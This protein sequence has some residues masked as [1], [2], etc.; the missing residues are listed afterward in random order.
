MVVDVQPSDFGQE[1]LIL[2]LLYGCL[3]HAPVIYGPDDLER[4]VASDY[5][6]WL[7]GIRDA[8]S[9]LPDGSEMPTPG[10]L[11]RYRERLERTRDAIREMRA[12]YRDRG[13]PPQFEGFLD[14]VVTPLNEVAQDIDRTIQM[15]LQNDEFALTQEVAVPTQYKERVAEYFRALSEAEA[16]NQ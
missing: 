11:T 6:R 3:T 12:A 4:F 10:D 13:V 14:Q 5:N 9:L 15:R 2:K 16:G 1:V 7:D 8:E